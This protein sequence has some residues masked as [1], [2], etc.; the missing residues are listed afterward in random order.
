MIIEDEEFR[1]SDT[2]HDQGQDEILACGVS[3]SSGV[4]RDR[5]FPRRGSTRVRSNAHR[6]RSARLATATPASRTFPSSA[7]DQIGKEPLEAGAWQERQGSRC[8][9]CDNGDRR[10][11]EEV[12]AQLTRIA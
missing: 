4:S 5:P 10:D 3:A 7:E 8:A 2:P 12:P 6:P 9:A 11:Q 1:A